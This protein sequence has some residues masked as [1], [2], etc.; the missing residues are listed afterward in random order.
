MPIIILAC[1]S[2]TFALA[3]DTDQIETENDK[4]FCRYPDY[5]T[6][7]N[8]TSIVTGNQCSSI[9]H[10][11]P[12]S[13]DVFVIWNATG[14]WYSGGTNWTA[15]VPVGGYTYTSHSVGSV[16]ERIGAMIVVTFLYVIPIPQI[17]SVPF[18]AIPYG[19]LFSM[20]GFGV[21]G[22]VRKG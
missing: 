4:L 9:S 15:T 20:I 17:A 10:P 6:G 19:I 22:K 13:D 21:Y 18:L 11:N 8:T 3:T 14:A 16:F 12:Y 2:I 7:W 5:D 1:L